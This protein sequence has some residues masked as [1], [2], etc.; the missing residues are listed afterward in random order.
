MVINSF[1]AHE[2]IDL[3]D[4]CLFYKTKTPEIKALIASAREVGGRRQT[5]IAD[6]CLELES[7][8]CSLS[9][10]LESRVSL[11]SFYVRALSLVQNLNSQLDTIH[12]EY[13]MYYYLLLLSKFMF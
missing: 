1:H 5:E 8:W 2:R 4:Y 13:V 12:G 9:G 7:R 6:N 10:I 3:F 11:A